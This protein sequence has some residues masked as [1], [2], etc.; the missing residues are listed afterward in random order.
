VADAL[1][2]GEDVGFDPVMLVGIELAGPRDAAL[3]FIENQHQPVLVAQ[4]PEP[5]H[6]CLRG[7]PDAAFALDRFDHD[8]GRVRPDQRL[9]RFQ[10]V[11]RRIFEPGEQRREAVVH[12]LLVR[13]AD[14][15]HRAAMEGVVEGDDLEPVRLACIARV[16][17]IGARGLDRGLDRLGAR[18]GEKHRVAEGCVDQ[19]LRQALA[20]GAAVKVRDVHQR[21]GLLLDRGDQP[22]V[23]VAEKVHRDA[24]RE[25]EVARAVLADQ[26]TMLAAHRPDTATRID[27]HERWYRHGLAS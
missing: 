1:G 6:E 14:G 11:E 27:G 5:L 17:V 22:L 25:V 3:H 10:I 24:A 21:R 19:P 20:L 7:G 2:S 13:G 15:C 4:R 26:V 18:I 23:R 12:L 16:L 9:G 8:A